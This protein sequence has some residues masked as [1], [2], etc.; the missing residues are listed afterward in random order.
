MRKFY[1][2]VGVDAETLHF[3]AE[4]S[5]CGKKEYGVKVPVLCRSVRTL[6]RCEKGKANKLSQA[7]YNRAKAKSTQLLAMKMNKCRH[8]YA[9]VCD[10]CY[11]AD[12]L[13]GACVECS[14]NKDLLSGK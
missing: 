4:C 1:K 3:C 10:N 9:W 5:I 14:K 6:A 8:C 13:L 2:N 12:D 11:D 7:S